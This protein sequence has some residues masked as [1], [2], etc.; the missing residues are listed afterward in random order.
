MNREELIKKIEREF[1][2]IRGWKNWE[3]YDRVRESTKGEINAREEL[4][5]ICIIVVKKYAKDI[6]E[7]K[8]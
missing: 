8:K 4:I 7:V 6:G 2:E 1:L 5:E 3:E